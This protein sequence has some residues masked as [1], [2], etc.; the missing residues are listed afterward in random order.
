MELKDWDIAERLDSEEDIFHY[1][2]AAFEEGDPAFITKALNDVARARGMT[3]L[4]KQ[5]DMSRAGL[6]R[7][8]G[9]DGNPSLSSLTAI[10]GA[11]GLRLAPAKTS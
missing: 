5:A 9:R 8:L 2:E 10:L 11:L 4:A 1:L 6:Y 7:A 3:E